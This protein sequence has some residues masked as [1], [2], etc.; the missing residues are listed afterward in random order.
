[1]GRSKQEQAGGRVGRK[2]LEKGRRER[3]RWERRDT[4]VARGP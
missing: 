4:S 2:E 3:K 1:M